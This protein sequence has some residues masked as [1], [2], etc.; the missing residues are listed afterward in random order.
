MPVEFKTQPQDFISATKGC[1]LPGASNKNI[2]SNKM[3]FAVENRRTP[4]AEFDPAK[5]LGVVVLNFSEI[6]ASLNQVESILS[7]QDQV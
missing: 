4:E 5:C 3:I 1:N 7:V 2:T 6:C